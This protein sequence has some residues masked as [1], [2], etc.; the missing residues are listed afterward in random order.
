MVGETTLDDASVIQPAVASVFSL[1]IYHSTSL[2]RQPQESCY[3]LYEKQFG[4]FSFPGNHALWLS[5]ELGRRY[6]ET[7]PDLTSWPNVS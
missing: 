7:S 4:D 6:R 5:D 1:S 3:G 2:T